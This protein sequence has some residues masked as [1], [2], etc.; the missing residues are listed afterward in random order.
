MLRDR[1]FLEDD[2]V[3]IFLARLSAMGID[4]AILLSTCDRV[5][6][7][8]IVRGSLLPMRSSELVLRSA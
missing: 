3:P 2:G 8:N 5:E 4:E 7:L 6:V 1:L